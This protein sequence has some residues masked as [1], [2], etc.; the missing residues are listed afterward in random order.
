M[1]KNKALFAEYSDAPS[2]RN[3]GNYDFSLEIQSEMSGTQPSH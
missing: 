2:R 3:W 1:L